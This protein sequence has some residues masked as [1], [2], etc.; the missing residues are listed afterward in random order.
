MQRQPETHAVMND[1]GQ[2][3]SYNDSFA[4]HKHELDDYINQYRQYVGVTHGTLVDFGSGTCNF[5]IALCLE[6]PDLKVVCYE[7]SDEMIK[8]AKD[9]IEKN[10]LSDRITIIKDDFFNASGSYDCVLMSRILHHINDTT[11]LWR[12]VSKLS[13]KILVTDLE[14]FS[15]EESFEKLTSFMKGVLEPIFYEDT[16]NSFKAAYTSEEVM[17]QV[18]D[19]PYTVLSRTM[20]PLPD[21]KYKK[22]TVYQTK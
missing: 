11:T 16:V 20:N 15:D 13:N 1:E 10:Q 19:F 22:M 14:R 17:E 21:I 7:L 6:F 4:N 9:N 8:I 3:R 12:V 2:C 5:V 18:K